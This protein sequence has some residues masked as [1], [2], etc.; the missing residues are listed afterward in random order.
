MPTFK[1]KSLDYFPIK[2]GSLN[3]SWRNW[4]SPNQGTIDSHG[5]RTDWCS[6]SPAVLKL[7][8]SPLL[9]ELHTQTGIHCHKAG[10]AIPAKC[11]HISKWLLLSF[12]A[13]RKHQVSLQFSAWPWNL[14]H[15]SEQ[16]SKAWNITIGTLSRVSSPRQFLNSSTSPAIAHLPYSD[17]DRNPCCPR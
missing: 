12:T 10:I 2:N 6:H 1:A 15:W 4:F 17:G 8:S 7:G 3:T 5:Q 9:T 13:L 16:N 11:V 14:S